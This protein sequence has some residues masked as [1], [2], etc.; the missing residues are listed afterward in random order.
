MARERDEKFVEKYTQYWNAGMTTTEMG[1]KLG[2][3]KNAICGL[4]KRMGL[5]PRPSPI[6][7][8]LALPGAPKPE[9]PKNP[10]GRPPKNPPPEP[11][12]DPP[13]IEAGPWLV[14]FN[15][16]NR[17]QRQVISTAPHEAAC[18][19]RS[20]GALW[21]CHCGVSLP[22][23]PLL[24]P[25]PP[26]PVVPVATTPDVVVRPMLTSLPPPPRRSSPSCCWP[27]GNPGK[28]TYCD[29]PAT[30][31]KPYCPEHCKLAYVKV[32]DRRMDAAD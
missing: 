4:R 25:L 32:R 7:R 2:R 27:L 29:D 9:R 10:V 28:F 26:R 12:Q 21:S 3:S 24:V 13:T 16:L 15:R 8:E 19:L 17:E 14:W 22:G 5:E 23:S 11:P 1:L 20:G 31:G 18:P 6:R 30:P